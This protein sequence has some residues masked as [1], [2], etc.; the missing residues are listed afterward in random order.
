MDRNKETQQNV[1]W[2]EEGELRSWGLLQ[3]SGVSMT[4]WMEAPFLKG[5]E[6]NSRFRV[7][8][9]INFKGLLNLVLPDQKLSN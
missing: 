3:I 5:K 4:R 8:E 6:K 9:G 2:Q 7:E 1:N